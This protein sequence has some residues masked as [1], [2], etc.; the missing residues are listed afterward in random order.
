LARRAKAIRGKTKVALPFWTGQFK[1]M[2]GQWP[3]ELQVFIDE[4]PENYAFANATREM[5]GEEV[6]KAWS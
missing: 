5:T 6:F 1:E 4:K 3:F 2:S